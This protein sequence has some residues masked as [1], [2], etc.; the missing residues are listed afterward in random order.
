MSGEDLPLVLIEVVLIG[1]GV[2]LFG[3]WQLRS[4]RLDRE[5][6]AKER[7]VGAAVAAATTARAAAASTTATDSQAVTAERP[8]ATHPPLEQ[9]VPPAPDRATDVD[10]VR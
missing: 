1:G 4:V 8:T 6:A 5:Q 10:R 2:L 9:A 7:A 3:W